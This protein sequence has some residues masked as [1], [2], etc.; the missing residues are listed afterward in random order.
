MKR[1]KIDRSKC[2]G[3]LTCVTACIV[4]HESSDARNR[5]TIDSKNKPAP[6]F[7]RHCDKPECVY[8]CMTGAMSKNTETGLVQYDKEQ[9]ASCYMCIMA[10][11]YGVLKSDRIQNKEIMK[12]NMCVHR[13][14]NNEPK[15]MCV[16]KCPMGAITL[17]EA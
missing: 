5:V 17:E 6:I 12:C 1:I 3:C 15:P 11:P 7:C 16:E 10:C 14:E 2:I 8:T 9:C 4:S 13:T